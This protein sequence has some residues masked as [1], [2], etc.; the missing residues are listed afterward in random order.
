MRALSK[1]SGDSVEYAIQSSDD[2]NEAMQHSE[3]RLV[4]KDGWADPADAEELIPIEALKAQ[5]VSSEDGAALYDKFKKY[6]LNYGPSFQ[7]VQEIYINDSFSLAKLKIA[8][9][10][11]NDFCQF[12]SYPV[13]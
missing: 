3:G 11:K 7:T 8:D 12:I 6:G 9:N 4:F 2:E 10:L 5:C 13:L 1:D